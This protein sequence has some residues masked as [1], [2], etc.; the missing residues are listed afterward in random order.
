LA[1]SINRRAKSIKVIVI[2]YTEELY[3]QAASRD[4]YAGPLQIDHY[5]VETT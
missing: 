2:L 5:F 1:G 3:V 4:E